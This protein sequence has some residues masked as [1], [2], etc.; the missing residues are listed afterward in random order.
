[1]RLHI[2][3]NV[4]WTVVRLGWRLAIRLLKIYVS[5]IYLSIRN[6]ILNGSIVCK[7]ITENKI[8]NMKRKSQIKSNGIIMMFV[9]IGFHINFFVFF[10]S[11]HHGLITTLLLLL[12]AHNYYFMIHTL[13]IPLVFK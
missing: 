9:L 10:S 3:T 8:N 12:Y 5:Y 1:M 2:N 4:L 7:I 6:E 11:Y 13:I